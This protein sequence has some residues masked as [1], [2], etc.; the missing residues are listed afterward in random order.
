VRRVR[1]RLRQHGIR[2]GTRSTRRHVQSG[3]A[4]LTL[5]EREVAGWVGQGQSNPEIAAQMFI[6]RRTVECHVARILQ[7]L[8]PRSRADIIRDVAQLSAQ[9]QT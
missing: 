8:Q 5:T 4:A 9:D 6:Y 2:S 1:Q 3:W 7:K